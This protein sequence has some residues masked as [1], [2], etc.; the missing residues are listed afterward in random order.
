MYAELILYLFQRNFFNLSC[1]EIY[2]CL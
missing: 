2:V 1:F